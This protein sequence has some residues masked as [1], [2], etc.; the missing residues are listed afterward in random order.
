[1]S[2]IFSHIK[3]F[4][5]SK[6]NDEVD[7]S[8]VSVNEDEKVSEK[9]IAVSV[10]EESNKPIIA[11]QEKSVDI[12][13]VEPVDV[14]SEENHN[15]QDENI[16]VEEQKE[17]VPDIPEE[18]E[19]VPDI[20]EEKETVPDIPEEKEDVPDVPEE[21][22]DV[23]EPKKIQSCGITGISSPTGKPM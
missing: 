13:N 5:W 3:T 6:K 7:I 11:T 9:T 22:E 14:A 10:E 18:K 2:S 19:T 16:P 23:P 20:P 4:L 21:K 15:M 17:T 1:M 8:G 12:A